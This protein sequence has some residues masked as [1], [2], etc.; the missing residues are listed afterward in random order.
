MKEA[1]EVY[2]FDKEQYDL[3]EAITKYMACSLGMTDKE[4]N[5]AVH[6]I[7]FDI[8]MSAENVKAIL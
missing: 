1:K 5:R 3:Q 2:P 7:I 4:I 6:P 8:V